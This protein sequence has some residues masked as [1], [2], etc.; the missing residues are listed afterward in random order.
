MDKARERGLRVAGAAYALDRVA[1]AETKVR[2]V[3][4][5]LDPA[6]VEAV[7][8]DID[9]AASDTLALVANAERARKTERRGYYVALALA[10][11]LLL[12]LTLKARQLD[13]RRARGVP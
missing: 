7:V 13:R 10:G 5:T 4:H 11:L 9:Q 12:T 6:R 2:G 1:T 3:V 8:G